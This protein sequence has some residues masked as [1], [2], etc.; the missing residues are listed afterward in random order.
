M[1]L[2]YSKNPKGNFGD[3]LNPYIFNALF[4]DLFE[5]DETNDIDF[6]GIGTIIGSEGILT[7]EIKS[8]KKNIFFGSGVRNLT[9][10]YSTDNWD[11]R[12]LRG[13]ISSNILGLNNEKFIT[14]GA[15]AYTTLP[16]YGNF[17]NKK[18]TYKFSFMPHLS[19]TEY[20][21]WDKL[22][23]R[24][25][26]HI[27]SPHQEVEKSLKEISET[28]YLIAGAMHGAIMADILRVPF[29][30]LRM[31]AINSES[32]LMSDFKWLDW[33]ASMSLKNVDVYVKNI[34]LYNRNFKE[35]ARYFFFLKELESKLKGIKN[36]LNIFQLSDENIFKEKMHLIDNEI[37]RL[38]SDY[39]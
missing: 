18:K 2:I 3:D 20:I 24:L 27:I 12:F 10:K 28:E 5:N 22:G 31:E 33:F 39:K 35:K 34:Y 15:Y 36:N 4:K 6:F 14:D 13:P 17:L 1:N 38:K 29:V 16:E 19:H 30:R 8:K 9:M 37:D 11:I 25:G 26:I 7:Q 32:F 21:D 23:S